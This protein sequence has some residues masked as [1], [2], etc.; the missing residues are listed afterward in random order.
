M[1]RLCALFVFGVDDYQPQAVFRPNLVLTGKFQ[2]SE[3]VMGEIFKLLQ[4]FSVQVSCLNKKLYWHQEDIVMFLARM[5][6][7]EAGP[8]KGILIS[9]CQKSFS[10]ILN[11]HL[12]TDLGGIISP[13]KSCSS[14]P[15]M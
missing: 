1:A 5:P 15:K 8:E 14:K 4:A 13:P 10:M 9:R 7:Y 6:K 12:S 11:N 2:H 3:T